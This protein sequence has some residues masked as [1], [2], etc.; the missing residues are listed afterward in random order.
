MAAGFQCR[1]QALAAAWAFWH[2][3]TQD[4]GAGAVQDLLAKGRVESAINL[5]DG[6]ANCGGDARLN[7]PITNMGRDH[8]TGLI[9]IPQCLQML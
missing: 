3:F 2:G 5:G 4:A 8:D 6:Q 7:L 9:I 1:E